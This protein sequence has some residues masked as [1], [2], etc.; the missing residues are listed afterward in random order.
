MAMEMKD[1][2]NDT[3]ERSFSEAVNLSVTLTASP[4]YHLIH[5]YSKVFGYKVN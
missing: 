5:T 1:N 3:K 2:D 4:Q